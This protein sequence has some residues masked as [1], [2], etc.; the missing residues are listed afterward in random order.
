MVQSALLIQPFDHTLLNPG[1]RCYLLLK[2]FETLYL[3]RP[4]HVFM[5]RG[6]NLYSQLLISAIRIS[7]ISNSDCGYQQF[8]NVSIRIADISNCE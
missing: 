8:G 5:A 1:E 3:F 6:I 2:R 4:L 7:D